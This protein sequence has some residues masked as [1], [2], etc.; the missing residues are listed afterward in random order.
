MEKEKD[1]RNEKRLG[2]VN[3]GGDVCMYKANCFGKREMEK[4][5]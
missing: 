5:C 4:K 1:F 2:S 3:G